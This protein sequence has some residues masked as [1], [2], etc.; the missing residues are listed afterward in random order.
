MK[1]LLAAILM[2]S[3]PLVTKADIFF[4]ANLDG[5]QEVPANGSTGAGTANFTLFANNTLGYSVT[6]SNLS[7]LMTASHIHGPAGIGTNAT[8]VFPL[9]GSGPASGSFAGTVG[10]LNASQVNTLL[11]GLYYINVHSTLVPGGEIRGQLLQVPEPSSLALLGL[12]TTALG[13]WLR[14]KQ[15]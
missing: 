12:G 13:I 14:R 6:Y 15:R 11:G 4:M 7:S 10:P 3:S 1:K 2:L 8:I 5:S 9:A